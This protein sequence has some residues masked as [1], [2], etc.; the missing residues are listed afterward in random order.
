[1]C[2]CSHAPVLVVID[3]TYL[4]LLRGECVI[5]A[6]KVGELLHCRKS[7]A[8][9]ITKKRQMKYDEERKMVQSTKQAKEKARQL[10]T[11][12]GGSSTDFSSP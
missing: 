8:R 9:R 6:R 12:A 11:G 10:T 2:L 5:P 1:M 3:K 4:I 7:D